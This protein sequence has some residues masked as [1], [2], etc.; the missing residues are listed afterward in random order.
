MRVGQKI[1]SI[2]HRR[3][4]SI[5]DISKETGVP[6]STVHY[7]K[8]KMNERIADAGTDFWETNEGRDFIVGLVIGTIYMFAIKAGNGGARLNEFFKLLNLDRYVGASNTTI[9]KI[10]KQ[11]EALILEYKQSVEMDI[12]NRREEIKLILGVDET[13]FDNMYLVCQ[14]LSSG[15]LFFEQES[16]KRDTDAWDEHI[17]K[18]FQLT[19]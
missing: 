1:L 14:D 10:I 4:K 7:H 3:D 5:R 13:W 9:L 12:R 11:V 8:Q 17:K 15:Y 6:K 2:F 16:E 18:T 19:S